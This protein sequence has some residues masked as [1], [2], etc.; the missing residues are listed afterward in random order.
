MSAFKQSK[1][2]LAENP[3]SWTELFLHAC[4]GPCAEA[5][6][7]DLME[8]GIKP[9]LYY[10]NPNIY[11]LEEWRRRHQAIEQ[12][13]E[14]RGLDLIAEQA[15]R[16]DLNLGLS[17]L[18]KQCQYCY[19]VRLKQ[20]AL[21]AKELGF[22]AFSTSLLVSPYQNRDYLL[23]LGRE[24]AAEYDLE[25]FA[26]DWRPLFRLGQKLAMEHGLYRQKYCA[27]Y[28]S[29]ASSKWKDKIYRELEDFAGGPIAIAE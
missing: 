13:A 17:G 24:A 12:L 14:L 9:T 23:Q 5:P 16:E 4:C 6:V 19:Q 27:C 8:A 25:F 26:V 22:K 20:A 18:P 1:E 7:L 3:A 15:S 21:R 10:F 28:Y 11:P 2:Y 29:L